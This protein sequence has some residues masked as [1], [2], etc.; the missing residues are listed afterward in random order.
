MAGFFSHQR[1]IP[2]KRLSYPSLSKFLFGKFVEFYET[3][4]NCNINTCE[5]HFVNVHCEHT[6]ERTFERSHWWRPNAFNWA[7]F[8]FNKL[9]RKQFKAL[10]G[11][12]AKPHKKVRR[13][14]IRTHNFLIR[15]REREV[16]WRKTFGEI[17]LH[18]RFWSFQYGIR[19]EFGTESLRFVT[20]L[21]FGKSQAF[22]DCW[23]QLIL[24]AIL[25]D[26][27]LLNFN[28]RT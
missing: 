28:F 11:A 21:N 13:S 19:L 17:E 20:A 24:T 2:T 14:C 23:S 1:E 27:P 8:F 5:V 3:D 15:V 25:F 22:C 12:R 7:I 10:L 6:Y 26:K 9:Q 16:L 4:D 18:R